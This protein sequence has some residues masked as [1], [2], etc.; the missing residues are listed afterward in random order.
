MEEMQ[1]FLEEDRRLVEAAQRGY[2]S[3]LAPGPAHRLEQ[4]ILQWQA[5]YSNL[6]ELDGWRPPDAPPASITTSPHGGASAPSPH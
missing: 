4:R 3:G 5:L 2:A 6:L 1:R